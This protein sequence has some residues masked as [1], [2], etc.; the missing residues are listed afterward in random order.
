M[1]LKSQH[2][3]NDII[4]TIPIVIVLSVDEQSFAA[5]ERPSESEVFSI[6][7]DTLYT[8]TG[9]FDF[10]GKSIPEAKKNLERVKIYQE[11]WHSWQT[12]HPGTEIFK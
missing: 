9:A 6:R 2:I 5:F 8:I 10:T 4:G 12:F 1:N 11:F 7:D 3:I